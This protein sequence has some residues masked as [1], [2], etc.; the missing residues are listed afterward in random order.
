MDPHRRGSF[1]IAWSTKRWR[2][3]AFKFK[4]NRPEAEKKDNISRSVE[5]ESLWL[6]VRAEFKKNRI[7]ADKKDKKKMNDMVTVI[8]GDTDWTTTLWSFLLFHGLFWCVRLTDC[9]GLFQSLKKMKSDAD[10]S[11]W[12]AS[13]VSSV[14]AILIFALGVR[15]GIPHFPTVMD[16][17]FV[18]SHDIEATSKI[19]LGYFLSD[20]AVLF[21]YNQVRLSRVSSRLVAI[22]RAR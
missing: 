1:C 17:F 13:F 6:R 11:Y 4:N 12:V 16:D 19:M 14:H 2:V 3:E 15:A 22:A 18:T 10:K 5:R 8:I 21:Y 9:F 20:M 7:E